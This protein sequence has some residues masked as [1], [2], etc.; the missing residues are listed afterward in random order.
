MPAF[1]QFVVRCY[2]ASLCLYPAELRSAYGRDMAEIFERL[3]VKEWN[4]SGPSGVLRVT[5]RAA[6]E[7]VT[8]AIPGHLLSER[9]FAV[10]LSLV[11]NSGILAFLVGEMMRQS[12]FLIHH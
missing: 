8:V 3:L 11:I 5:L 6:G 2:R 12:S 9:M 10:G 7:V 1:L 4:R